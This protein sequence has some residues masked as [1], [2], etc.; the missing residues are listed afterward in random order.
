MMLEIR[1][2]VLVAR[3]VADPNLQNEAPP[4]VDAA[5]EEAKE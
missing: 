3:G 2:K 5:E 4:E 1:G